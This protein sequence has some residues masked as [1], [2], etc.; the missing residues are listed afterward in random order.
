MFNLFCFFVMF[1]YIYIYIYS[2]FFY[3]SDSKLQTLNF[4]LVRSSLLQMIHPRRRGAGIYAGPLYAR[5]A[6]RSG[7]CGQ[8]LI[9]VDERSAA[10][11]KKSSFF[12]ILWGS[13]FIA[14]T[15]NPSNCLGIAPLVRSPHTPTRLC[16]RI[17][18]GMQF[19]LAT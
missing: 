7:S 1:I 15:A 19:C 12:K 14:A 9:N 11:E 10:L 13:F 5:P 2:Y 3:T 4:C 18:F 6:A 17:E 16:R 8:L